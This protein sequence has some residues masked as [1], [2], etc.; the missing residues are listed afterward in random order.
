[1][2]EENESMNKNEITRITTTLGDELEKDRF[3]VYMLC[4]GHK[5]FYIGKGQGNRVW[6][7][8]CG[9][10]E[11]Q[12]EIT[13]HVDEINNMIERDIIK[14][15][16]D[17][18]LILSLKEKRKYLIEQITNDISAKYSKIKSLKEKGIEINKVIVKWG[19]T[20]EESF[21]VESALMNMY[22]YINETNINIENKKLQHDEKILTNIVNG[23]MSKREK[24][25][26]SHETKARSVEEFL[27]CCAIE[28]F[29]ITELSNTH[30]MF[31]NISRTYP[32]CK[33]LSPDEQ[34]KAIY[35]C[36]RAAWKIGKDKIDKVEYVFA[37]YNSQVV[38]IYKVDKSSWC[39]RKNLPDD[40]SFPRY[41][42]AVRER[43]W[44]YSQALKS[45]NSVE[46][47]E[48]FCRSTPSFD[49]KEMYDVIGNDFDDWKNRYCFIASPSDIPIE[50]LQFKNKLL[51]FPQ[52][53]G[54][55]RKIGQNDRFNFKVSKKNGKEIAEITKIYG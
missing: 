37:L 19:L 4:E 33:D 17:T 54:K 13:Y 43:E 12:A 3:Y 40:Y 5:P 42:L 23:H 47:A 52:Q 34:E 16:G 20:E 30:V 45:L 10:E 35:D 29:F 51:Y 53:D 24:K 28:E 27:D 15:K 36:S 55:H 22:Y 31:V 7:H 26:I 49:V 32:D 11:K 38:G 2:S 44:K 48:S 39:Q 9:E 8:E 6:Q 1:M 46:D 25:N 14:A 50:I 18:E 41:P 21:M